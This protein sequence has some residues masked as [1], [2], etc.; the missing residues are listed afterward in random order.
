MHPKLQPARC[1]FSLPLGCHPVRP[2]AIYTVLPILESV[3]YSHHRSHCKG[4]P[5]NAI[6]ITL[7][8]IGSG[9]PATEPRW[10][11]K[12]ALQTGIEPASPAFQAYML[13]TAPQRP[14]DDHTKLA[15]SHSTMDSHSG[16]E[17]EGV[18][19]VKLA[20]SSVSTTLW[21]VWVDQGKV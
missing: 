19:E 20:F 6:C 15:P 11:I 14:S 1:A 12:W 4:I 2:S 8:S 5:P 13:T 16:S 21:C 9:V 3:V 17:V 10:Q 7:S 18:F